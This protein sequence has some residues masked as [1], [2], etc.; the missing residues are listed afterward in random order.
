M[1][2]TGFSFE[3][4]KQ[5]DSTNNYAMAKV[6]AG[7]AKHGDACFSM[8]QTQGKGQRGKAWQ[9]GAEEN[10][11]LSVILNPASLNTVH[12]FELS[13]AIA[14]A[15]FDFFS[16]YAGDETS[17]KWPNDIY[18]RDR[19]A[20]GILI[21]N[22]YSGKDWKWAIVGIGININQ[23]QFEQALVN[24]VSL[25]Q[26]TGQLYKPTELAKELHG[27]VMVRINELLTKPYETRLREYNLHLYKINQ[28]VR[29]KKKTMV[30]ET[31]IKGVSPQGQLL[32][33]DAIER[34]FE[35]GQVEW[36]IIQ[37]V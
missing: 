1:P 24:P 22:K 28:P 33:I 10:I 32:T 20:G 11:A 17:I 29:L 3:I 6:H 9:T 8:D 18:W 4:L 37:D 2:H 19:K 36:V 16:K 21:E 34:H 30:F 13:A 14:L 26:I 35:F 7:M 31:V 15:S 27:L 25:L 23:S 12:P 5:V